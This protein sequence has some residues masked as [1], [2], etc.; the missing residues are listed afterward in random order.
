MGVKVE[1]VLHRQAW[2]ILCDESVLSIRL[3]KQLPLEA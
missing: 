2:K 3:A 1:F